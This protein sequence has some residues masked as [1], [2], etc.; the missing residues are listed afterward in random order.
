MATL[1]VTHAANDAG[2][3]G[4]GSVVVV[5]KG[6]NADGSD[7]SMTLDLTKVSA[8]NMAYAA[9]H[10]IKQ[11]LVDAAALSRDT[12]TGLAASPALKAESIAEIIEHL[13]S[14]TEKWSRVASSSGVKG[15]FLFEALCEMNPAE[16]PAN[17]RAFLDGLTAAQQAALREDDEV[18]PV[19]AR[20]K[21]DR[22]K[23]GDVKPDTK[24]LLA[25]LKAAPAPE[26]A[27]QA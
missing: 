13:E 25:G 18:A 23:P 7:L 22:V 21:R 10:G 6:G 20:I 14:G 4:P 19:I 15:G 24:A 16:T 27:P 11:R 17:V 2:V 3:E 12:K 1:T 5:V 8:A 9:F 26:A